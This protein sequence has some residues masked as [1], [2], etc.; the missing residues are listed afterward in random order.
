MVWMR[1]HTVPLTLVRHV[2][3]AAMVIQPI[4]PG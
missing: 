1:R 3:L 4:P 2:P